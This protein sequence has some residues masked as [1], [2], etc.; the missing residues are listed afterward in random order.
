MGAIA[1]VMVTRLQV[2]LQTWRA[3]TLTA[4]TG[5]S[6]VVSMKLLLDCLELVV[7]V[8]EEVE[9]TLE[10]DLEECRKAEH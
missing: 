10:E 1:E 8:E 5:L 2:Q 7:V 4:L 9:L 6:L 3:P